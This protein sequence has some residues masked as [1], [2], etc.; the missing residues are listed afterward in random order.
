MKLTI[1]GGTGGVGSRL[2]S[3]AIESGHRVTAFAR[4][5][6][7]ATIRELRISKLPKALRP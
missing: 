7:I 2:V 6:L 5:H 3:M 4:N 1:F